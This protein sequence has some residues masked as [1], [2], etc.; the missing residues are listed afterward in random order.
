[1]HD[2]KLENKGGISKHYVSKSQNLWPSLRICKIRKL[3]S[4]SIPQGSFY[5]FLEHLN[6]GGFL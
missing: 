1:M 3:N 6:G 4:S 5:P 2:E